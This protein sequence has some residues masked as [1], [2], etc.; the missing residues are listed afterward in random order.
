M[1]RWVA[2]TILLCGVAFAG[3]Q[4]AW[5]EPPSGDYGVA[6]AENQAR[7]LDNAFPLGEPLPVPGLWNQPFAPEGLTGCLEMDFYRAQWH[8]PPVFT[9]M[10][11]RESSCD[12]KAENSCCHG[13]WQI[14]ERYWDYIP[15]CDVYNIYS[16]QGDDPLA[17]QRNA[18]AAAYVLIKQG[19]RA[20]TTCPRWAR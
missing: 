5:A 8:L 14:H 9:S 2:A 18:C 15:V 4:A 11:F 3:V 6:H 20:W 17:K 19:C 10:G 13:Y 16:L 12:N 1:R 7:R